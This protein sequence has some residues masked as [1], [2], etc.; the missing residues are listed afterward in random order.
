M[1]LH[2]LDQAVRL[3]Y[4]AA[5]TASTHKTYKVAERRYS[6]FCAE[7]ALPPFPASE[8]I[9][10]YY[11]ACLGQQG[12]A[13]STIKTYLSGVRQLQIS[14]G[15]PEPQMQSMPRLRQVLK[16]VQVMRGKEGRAPRPRLPITPSV[17]R[18]IR[19]VWERKGESADA[20]LLWAV[21]TTTFF[22]FCRSGEVVVEREDSYDPN[23]HLSFRD[24]SVDNAKEPRMV[25]LLLRCSKTDQARRGVKVVMGRTGDDICPVTALLQYLADRGNR[26]GPLFLRANG[27]PL[28]KAQ[29]VAEVRSALTEAKLPAA[30]YAGHSFR[31]GAATTAAAAGVEDSVIQTLGRWKSSAYLLYVRMDPRRLASISNTLAS[32]PI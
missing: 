1:D 10:C 19:A 27:K 2:H 7:F 11:V 9:L 6:Q 17:L 26:P 29:L 25:S 22:T 12:L 20:R 24:I 18:K 15:L 5:L 8:T 31:I 16:G 32:C 13:H 21:A 30:S 28:T 14:M 4:T 3:Y 23:S